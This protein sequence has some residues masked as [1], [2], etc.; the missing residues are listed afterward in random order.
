MSQLRQ[1]SPHSPILE[2]KEVG[3]GYH[4]RGRPDREVLSGVSLSVTP[5][6]LVALLGPNGS[7]KTTMFR[8]AVGLLPA[9]RGSVRLDGRP[10]V[11]WTRREVA[12][13]IAILPQLPTVPD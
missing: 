8:V 13:R 9:A 1:P 12:Q 11:D 7:G 5:G 4:R 10:L 2:L 3:F 6:E